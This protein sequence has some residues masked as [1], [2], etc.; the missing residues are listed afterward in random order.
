MNPHT[1]LRKQVVIAAG[2]LCAALTHYGCGG[3]GSAPADA[4][5]ADESI[6]VSVRPLLRVGEGREIRASG[7]VISTSEQRLAF[8]IGGVVQRIL[9][10]EGQQVRQGQ[11]LAALDATEIDA[12]VTQAAEAL[13]KAERDLQRVSNLYRDSSATL[14]MYQNAGTARDL[15]AEAL[16]IARFN[17]Q[18]A[19]IR[20]PRSGKVLRKLVNEGEI[21]GPGVPA[22]VVYES[23]AAHWAVKLMLSDKDW[24]ALRLGTP[25]E[26]RIDAFQDRPITGTVSELAPA[27]DPVSGL[28]AVE[29]RFDPRDLRLAPGL[30]ATATLRPASSE[31]LVE[32]PIEALV[33]GDGREAFV[34]APGADGLTARKI[35][36]SVAQIRGSSVL[37]RPL[38]D[39]VRRVVTLGSPY[40]KDGKKIKIVAE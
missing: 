40:L 24:A 6:P 27:A 4:E 1:F 8:K 38:P 33:E 14:E 20:A 37:L 22:F 23:G 13:N 26:I 15:A 16:R 39:S 11:L 10:K 17:R 30:F 12:Q 25:A 35:P 21:V 18:Y 9:V 34:F 3:P 31:A 28:Y 29:L 5:S 19:E 32:A 36:V 2:I 7:R